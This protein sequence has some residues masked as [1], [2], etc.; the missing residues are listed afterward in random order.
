MA[1]FGL[2]NVNLLTKEQFDGLAE[3]K[4]DELWVV[5]AVKAYTD[6]NGN[7]YRVY[8][9]GWC[10]QGGNFGS[11]FA[12]WSAKTITLLVPFRDNKYTLQI[13]CGHTSNTDSPCVNTKSTTSFSCTPYNSTG[14]ANWFACGYT[15]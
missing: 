9:D 8:P 4:K 12:S 3:P 15:E 10:E 2:K 14:N 13:I 5:E 6:D 7:W 11:A 1:T